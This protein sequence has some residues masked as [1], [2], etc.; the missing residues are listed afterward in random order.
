[1]Q[2]VVVTGAGGFLGKAVC[3]L[4]SRNGCNVTR[5]TSHL[6]AGK[7]MTPVDLRAADAVDRLRRVTPRAHSL[8]H[9]AAEIP[10]KCRT[11]HDPDVN[12]KMTANCMKWA[13]D[14]GVERVV[15]ASS[16]ALYGCTQHQANEDHPVC[17]SDW[18]TRGKV[19]CEQ[20]LLS[21]RW[22][23]ISLRLSAPYGAN[24]PTLTVMHKFLLSSVKNE[25]IIVWGTGQ[26][27]QHFV[28]I[29]DAA[30]S[31]VLACE[32][33]KSGVFNISGPESVSMLELAQLCRSAVN[34]NSRIVLSGLDPQDNFRGSFPHTKAT[35][36]L[37][38]VP[39]V[40]IKCGIKELAEQI[41]AR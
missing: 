21:G 32:S 37:G 14:A 2:S 13:E 19:E 36:D 41:Q 7:D 31:F 11:Q 4:L 15:F 5:V 18:Y 39:R 40:N 17:D 3:E 35:K 12:Q 22:R 33:A 25:D 24:Q 26:R 8:I 30:Q 16:C 38:Y 29:H 27:T 20:M 34:S 10:G 6:F 1:V 23:T 28:A 9:L